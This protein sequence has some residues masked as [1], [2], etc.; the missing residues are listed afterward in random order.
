MRWLSHQ[1]V[2][3][4]NLHEPSR[5]NAFRV[6]A[7]KLFVSMP[8]RAVAI[9]DEWDCLGDVV[10]LYAPEDGKLVAVTTSCHPDSLANLSGAEHGIALS[11]KAAFAPFDAPAQVRI[12]KA[13]IIA[14]LSCEDASDAGLSVLV[15]LQLLSG[16]VRWCPVKAG[17]FADQ[18]AA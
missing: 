10:R 13:S 14:A 18:C 7:C 15:R 6:G 1:G 5:T 8:N 3:L 11:F 4:N 9:H 17:T 2:S 12:F 16:L